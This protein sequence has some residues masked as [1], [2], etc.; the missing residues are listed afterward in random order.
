MLVMFDVIMHDF[1]VDTS[2]F[3]GRS[4]DLQTG[5]GEGECFRCGIGRKEVLV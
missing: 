2:L 3:G 1:L 5:I 4:R